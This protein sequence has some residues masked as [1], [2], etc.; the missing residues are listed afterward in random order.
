MQTM[1]AEEGTLK[2]MRTLGAKKLVSEI[3]FSAD[4]STD[5][6]YQDS[7]K[8]ACCSSMLFLL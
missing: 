3:M 2:N 1:G 5:E 4:I 7:R 6:S 8:Q